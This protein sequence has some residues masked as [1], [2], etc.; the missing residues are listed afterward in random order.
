MFKTLG[1]KILGDLCNFG[2][3]VDDLS[4]IYGLGF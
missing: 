4:S 3:H 1:G 2:H